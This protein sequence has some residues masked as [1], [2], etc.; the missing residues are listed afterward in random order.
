MRLG[1]FPPGADRPWRS[2]LLYVAHSVWTQIRS[3]WFWVAAGIFPVAMAGSIWL[4]R[5]L[6]DADSKVPPPLL[7]VVPHDGLRE[8]LRWVEESDSVRLA[9][10][11]DDRENAGILTL[12]GT[13]VN[14][15]VPTLRGV[16]EDELARVQEK[17]RRIVRGAWLR[18]FVPEDVRERVGAGKSASEPATEVGDTKSDGLGKIQKTV[19]DVGNVVLFA[20]LFFAAMIGNTT[21]ARVS[22]SRDKGLFVVLRVG[23]PA[24]VLFLAAVFEGL[25]LS[26]VSF[27]WIAIPVG[28]LL[29]AGVAYVLVTAGAAWMAGFL[30]LWTV[31]LGGISAFVLAFSTVAAALQRGQ[32]SAGVV[33]QLP[34]FVLM[35]CGPMLMQG[36]ALL[37]APAFAA[38]PWLG[39]AS[40]LPEL[41]AGRVTSWGVVGWVASLVLG[42]AALRVGA[43][44]YAHES[45]TPSD[46]LPRLLRRAR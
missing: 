41:A 10:S 18:A 39:V 34:F 32:P 13:S 43:W 20:T 12:A 28:L 22:E 9:A 30:L 5:V 7:V 25:L 8:T 23:T 24:E 1:F 31:A 27:A 45:L 16:R 26:I 6:G 15:I 14:E 46:L 3:P 37:R 38:I 11:A 36:E 2:I 19:A 40:S 42:L 17:A 35:L 21:G 4:E 33:G 44:A 29:V